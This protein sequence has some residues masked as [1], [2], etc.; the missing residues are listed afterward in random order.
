M[1]TQSPNDS[2]NFTRANQFEPR[3]PAHAPVS[4]EQRDYADDIYPARPETNFSQ[5]LV[6]N[7]REWR[8]DSLR[9]VLN[10]E[11]FDFPTRSHDR[12]ENLAH[13][14]GHEVFHDR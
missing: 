9:D 3:M 13:L 5:G 4:V 6:E 7:D 8:F 14:A 2:L 12:S 11:T 1:E 10:P